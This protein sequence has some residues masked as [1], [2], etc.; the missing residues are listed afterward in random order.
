MKGFYET[1]DSGFY[2]EDGYFYIMSRVDDIIN[3]A[4]HRLSTGEM[5]EYLMMHQHVAEAIVVGVFDEIKGEV[6]V[7]FVT[8]KS[9]HKVD[10]KVLQK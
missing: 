9:G 5:E 4:G 3:T 2:D 7:G 6:P 1:G 10:P 8:V